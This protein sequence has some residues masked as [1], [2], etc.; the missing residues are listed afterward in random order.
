MKT[1]MKA[2]SNR[3]HVT[4]V[5]NLIITLVSL[6]LVGGYFASASTGAEGGTLT[7]AM[8]SEPPNLDASK[9]TDTVSFF[10]L[11]H[12]ME[13]LA[14]YD[15]NGKLVPGVAESWKI[16][17]S[18][19]VFH[20]RKNA[21]WSDGKP[22]VAQDFVYS[23]NTAVN[24]KTASEYAF[25]LYNVKNG[26]AINTKK[27]PSAKLGVEATDEHTLKVTFEKPC[28][29]F[30]AL[31]TFGT[32]YPMR[33]DVHDQF[34]AKYAA[35]ADKMLYNGPYVLT[36]WVHGASLHMDKNPNYWNKDAI[37]IAALD[38]PY[39]TSDEGAVFNL[40][41]DHKIEAIDKLNKET[42]INAQKEKFKL[43]KFA[44]GFLGYLQ[45]NFRP[46]RVTANKNFRKAIQA[47][48]N[49]TEYV[50]TVV[51]VPGTQA[52]LGLIPKSLPGY[53][54]NSYRGEFPL[55]AQRQNFA[56]AKEYLQLSLKELGMKQIPP[57]VWL[58]RDAPLEA[59]EAEYFQNILKNTLGIEIRIDRQI[60]KQRIA[61]QIAG[62]FDIC[63]T[64]WGPDY[65][66][67]MTFADLFSSWNENNNGKWVN[68]QY[69]ALIRQAQG[70]AD[71]KTRM[72]KMSEAEKILMEELPM[73]PLYERTVMYTSSPNVK[74]IV[75]RAVGFDP[76]Y[77]YAQI[78]K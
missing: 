77:R 28:G 66:D 11:G 46:G 6:N 52:G 31:T 8:N 42:L 21:K 62:D 30:L 71:Q 73:V 60:F 48:F 69:D 10:V 36:K 67:P 78:V 2:A 75:R 22:V 70:T 23:W 50:S 58:T 16:N 24:P 20:L 53:K 27:D 65:N 3:F 61:K 44:D 64:A 43:A 35:D 18:G 45:F 72:T 38:V 74:G 1:S 37:K 32:Y 9:A 4:L 49:P 76:D 55:P 63:S 13:G 40:F 12:T 57:L 5:R 51:G 39:I 26:E 25:I 47:I 41:K 15:Q 54:S 7:I 68:P 17:D 29:F 34:G 19:A 56:K 33:K 14:R 59:K